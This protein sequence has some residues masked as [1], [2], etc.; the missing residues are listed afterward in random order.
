M[1]NTGDVWHLDA[2]LSTNRLRLWTDVWYFRIWRICH[3]KLKNTTC[4]LHI[5][6]NNKT[7]NL[8]E[9]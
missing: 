4:T 3:L 1:A 7:K 9:M 5:S 6:N 2:T 8:F